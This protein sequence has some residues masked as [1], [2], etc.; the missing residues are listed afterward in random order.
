MSRKG[1]KAS[2]PG[3]ESLIVSAC[4]LGVNSCYDGRNRANKK[5]IEFCKKFNTLVICPEILGGLPVPRPPAEIVKGD[6]N[7]VL[8]RKGKVVNREGEDVTEYFLRGAKE[9]LK[10][11]KS[12]KVK[13]AILKAR[14]PSCGSGWIYDGSFSG[15]L[16]KGDGVSSAILKRNGINVF[17]E[18][19]VRKLKQKGGGDD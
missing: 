1:P 19:E 12:K 16:K 3:T 10:I 8:A 15:K 5:V 6:G 11:A 18:E 2:P 7:S 4:L 14:S 13:F 17:T 9:V